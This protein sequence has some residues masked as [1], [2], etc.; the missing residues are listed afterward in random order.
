MNKKLTALLYPPVSAPKATI[1]IRIMTGS[2]FFWE[3]ILKFVDTNQ[4]VGRFTKIGFPMPAEL[5]TFVAILEIVGGLCLIFGYRTRVFSLLFIG[6]MIVAILSTKIALL[7][8]TS[9]LPLPP[10]PPQVGFWAVLHEARTDFAQLMTSIFLLIVGPGPLS[11]DAQVAK[12]N[13]VVS[14]S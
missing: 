9:P 1:L 10:A 4:G 2:V 3:G 11:A 6:Q 8:A 14:T 7:L 5:A 12:K 13:G